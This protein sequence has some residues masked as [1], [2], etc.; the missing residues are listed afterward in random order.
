MNP[1]SS[2]T[3][4]TPGIGTPPEEEDDLVFVDGEEDERSG[5]R[6]DA[7]PRVSGQ[8][9]Q[10]A[11]KNPT[12]EE[13]KRRPAP[14]PRTHGGSGEHYKVTVFSTDKAGHRF[15]FVP[16]W[17]AYHKILST[18]TCLPVTSAQADRIAFGHD[19]LPAGAS[20]LERAQFDKRSFDH[21]VATAADL[22]RNRLATLLN[23]GID[24]ASLS[25]GRSRDL[26]LAAFRTLP[27]SLGNVITLQINNAPDHIPTLTL[28]ERIALVKP[29]FRAVMLQVPTLA[30]NAS[31][32][33]YMGLHAL[34]YRL[35][36]WAHHE[37]APDFVEIAGI[38]KHAKAEHLQ[39]GF[40]GV[41]DVALANKLAHA[42][43]TYLSGPFLGS[44]LD[45]PAAM[46][47][48]TLEEIALGPKS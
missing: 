39:F 33:S 22:Q 15:V 18:Y 14:A 5:G 13:P 11:A 48:C 7:E 41:H 43:A 23:F 28:G 4:A 30:F 19:L 29:Y 37:R 25:T 42:G 47:R 46:R 8:G 45:I 1:D 12:A 35:W 31:R 44:A 17:D 9:T 2:T 20:D 34:I 36:D 27:K 16:I 24:Y 21:V 38:I 40:A 3:A 10:A 32:F 26:L 6:T